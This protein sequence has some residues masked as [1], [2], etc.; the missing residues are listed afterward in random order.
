MKDESRTINGICSQV[1]VNPTEFNEVLRRIERVVLEQDAQVISKVI[2]TFYRRDSKATT[3]TLNGVVYQVP[4]RSCVQL[5]ANK[6]VEQTPICSEAPIQAVSGLLVD[7][8]RE[9]FSGSFPGLA[10]GARM[11]LLL[12][13]TSVGNR[14]AAATAVNHPAISSGVRL[15]AVGAGDFT[16]DL[17]GINSLLNGGFRFGYVHHPDA[18]V[19]LGDKFGL[20]LEVIDVSDSGLVDC[21]IDR[22]LNGVVSTSVRQTFSGCDI[23][24][25]FVTS[26]P[27]TSLTFDMTHGPDLFPIATEYELLVG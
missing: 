16:S 11:E 25:S 27:D 14:E 8:V 18:E 21:R 24:A 13:V 9:E 6:V 2:G 26:I 10:V 5:R 3:K 17:F 23:E 15:R 20:A 12:E 19:V 1:G 4:A 7:N 22:V